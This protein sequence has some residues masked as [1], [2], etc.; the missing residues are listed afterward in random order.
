MMRCLYLCLIPLLLV[1]SNSCRNNCEAIEISRPRVEY[2]SNPQGIDQTNPRFSWELNST[3]RNKA[4]SAYQIVV[5]KDS[6]DFESDDALV[7]NSEKVKSN[8]TNGV[9]YQGDMLQSGKPYFWKV[10]AWDEEGNRSQW[11]KISTWSMGMLKTSNWVA[12]WIGFDYHKDGGDSTRVLTV[13]QFRTTFSSDKVLQRAVLYISAQGLFEAQING[14]PVTEDRF[15]PG[16]SDYNKRIYYDTYD[17]S[18]L[19]IKGENCLGVEVANGWYTGRIADIGNRF[20]GDYPS[21]KAQL[22]LNYDDGSADTIFTDDHWQAR[23]GPRLSSDIIH[24]E[25]FHYGLDDANWSLATYSEEDWTG[26]AIVMQDPISELA[27]YPTNHIRVQDTIKPTALYYNSD[28]LYIVDFGQNF[29]GVA[30]IETRVNGGDTVVVNYAEMLNSDSTLYRNN[31]RGARCSDTIIADESGLISWSPKFTYRG[32]RYVS[33]QSSG[34]LNEPSVTGL[35]MFSNNDRVGEFACSSPLINT[36]NENI[37]RSINSNMFDIP[38]D[39][40]Q[41]DERLG[42]AADAD[43]ILTTSAFN[44]DV[45]TFYDKWLQSLVHAQSERGY[46]PSTAPV[47]RPII[48]SGWGDAITSVPLKLFH[49]YGDTNIL[50]GYYPEM[51]AWVDFLALRTFNWFNTQST[52]GDWQHY[53]DPTSRRTN[54][55]AYFKHSVNN[56]CE[57]AYHLGEHNDY[58]KYKELGEHINEVFN[59]Y[60]INEAGHTID[61]SQTSCLYA[62]A[63]SLVDSQTQRIVQ[64]QLIDLIEKRDKHL[65]TG[66]LGTALILDELVKMDSIELAY[67]LIQN[68][69]LP[70]WGYQIDNG[71]TTIWEKWDGY[72][73]ETGMNP[74][75]NNSLNHAALGSVGQWFYTHIAGIQA[76]EPGFKQIRIKPVIG[77]GLTWASAQYRSIAGKIESH[78][79]IHG[80]TFLLDV[81]IPV[82]TV[83]NVYLPTEKAKSIM[84]DGEFIQDNDNLILDVKGYIGIPIGSDT[85]RFRCLRTK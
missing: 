29:A 63:Y 79:K 6:L 68:R 45:L 74:D 41:R 60:Q 71:A 69:E 51:K 58:R 15:T 26:R 48:S 54:S 32:F 22:I 16:W 72:S 31:L 65:S 46:L 67:Q 73:R 52:Y 61:S 12:N 19:L 10:C 38:T 7:W 57:A 39:C 28:D 23:L 59:T 55:I 36:I 20:Y 50:R 37:I 43:V 1:A 81:T 77:G 34:A 56:F 80:D 70:S 66:I 11:S 47:V 24:G 78:W 83:A 4:Q 14:Q 44:S 2:R 53:N 33:I 49:L 13:P 40:P 5:S 17:V 8:R 85:Y 18:N 27:A 30:R 64:Q 9:P 35:V 62:L 3:D 82:N 76:T 21:F 25:K 75:P 84:V 42:W